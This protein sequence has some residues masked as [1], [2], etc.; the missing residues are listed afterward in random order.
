MGDRWTLEANYAWFEH[1]VKDE[2]EFAP[3]GANA[4]PHKVNLGLVY[5]GDRFS[6]SARYRWSDDFRWEEGVINGPVPSYG[7][8]NVVGVY[9]L[10]G[11]WEIGVNVSNLL[12]DRHYEF[13]SGDIMEL[14]AVAHVA[15]R[16]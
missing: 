3:L 2:L 11:S 16:W 4:P 9:E 6:G 15:Y 14:R 13:F 1:V 10:P 5:V 7:V 8:L 12:D